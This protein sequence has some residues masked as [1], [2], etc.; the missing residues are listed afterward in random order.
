MLGPA[1]LALALAAAACPGEII[2]LVDGEGDNSGWSV[3]PAGAVTGVQVIDVDPEDLTVTITIEKDFP[4]MQ[5]GQ[6]P[7][8]LLTFL[9]QGTLGPTSTQVIIAG[10]TIANNTGAGWSGYQWAILQPGVAR[11]DI[12]ASAGWQVWPF[13]TQ[14]WQSVVGNRAEGLLAGNGLVPD[15]ATFVPTGGLVIGIDLVVPFTLKQLPVPEPASLALV[16]LG[17]GALAF[18]RR[19][20]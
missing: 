1:V 7:S 3:W 18:R 2:P 20:R 10:E 15:G 5:A 12:A 9:P 4:P 11:F 16:V 14:T 8:A 19:R 13:S 17:A 6:M